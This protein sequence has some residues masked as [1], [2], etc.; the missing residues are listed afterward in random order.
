MFR[1]AQPTADFDRQF[2]HLSN[3]IVHKEFYY[4][5][6][7]APKANAMNITTLVDLRAVIK[8]KILSGSFWQDIQAYYAA[9][10]EARKKKSIPAGDC[11]ELENILLD[12]QAS[13]EGKIGALT[14]FYTR[15]F[16]KRTITQIIED[17]YTVGQRNDLATAITQ[18]MPNS[19][20]YRRMYDEYIQVTESFKAIK[21]RVSKAID[22]EVL[23][24]SFLDT[25]LQNLNTVAPQIYFLGTPEDESA[26]A[27]SVLLEI[28]IGLIDLKANPSYAPLV[29]SLLADIRSMADG[30]SSFRQQLNFIQSHQQSIG[31]KTDIDPVLKQTLLNL[32][33]KASKDI[34][35]PQDENDLHVLEIISSI[36]I[37]LLDVHVSSREILIKPLLEKLNQFV[38]DIR[39]GK[40]TGVE[41]LQAGGVRPQAI[42]QV[43]N[44][45]GL[46]WLLKAQ[47]PITSKLPGELEAMLN[48]RTNNNNNNNNTGHQ[49]SSNNNN[50]NLLDLSVPLISS[51]ESVP[52][53]LKVEDLNNQ[54]LRFRIISNILGYYGPAG[55]TGLADKMKVVPLDFKDQLEQKQVEG[56]IT[57][58]DFLDILTP[59]HTLDPS[60]STLFGYTAS[61]QDPTFV[62]ELTEMRERALLMQYEGLIERASEMIQRQPQDKNQIAEPMLNAMVQALPLSKKHQPNT[63]RLYQAHLKI[64]L[65]TGKAGDIKV[66]QLLNSLYAPA[67]TPQAKVNDLQ[68]LQAALKALDKPPVPKKSPFFGKRT[69]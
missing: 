11:A 27:L 9:S 46:V 64:I 66:S 12:S 61:E 48:Q 30:A 62:L 60:K 17:G 40:N 55:K 37:K 51:E 47:L 35:I 22:E 2:S 32:F 8:A 34:K 1:A 38:K 20:K 23:D 3:V 6:V 19:N 28:V 43:E 36:R 52:W 49:A 13:D 42:N 14:E 4:Q 69:V 15:H 53:I 16:S 65:G 58:D 63:I 45:P 57:V 31:E 10:T 26:S 5:E 29:Q 33:N 18:A 56:C 24:Q 44:L 67:K 68:T 54:A 25:Q 21:R 39:E 41:L 50:N 7:I 59:K